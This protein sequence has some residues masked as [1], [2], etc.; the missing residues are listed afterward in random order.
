MTTVGTP[1]PATPP[2]RQFARTLRWVLGLTWTTSP[3][4]VLTVLG[5]ALAR[6]TVAAGLALS[7]RGLINAVVAESHRSPGHLAPV[8]PWLLAALGFGFIEVLAPLGSTRVIQRL[9]DAIQLRVNVDIL[10]HASLLGT[11][12]TQGPSGRHLLES[13]RD[14]AANKLG[15][16]VNELLTIVSDGAQTVLLAAV[17]VH[18]EPAT[19]VVVVPG[20]AAYLYA[21]WRMT[22]LTHEAAPIRLLRQRWG[23]YL[24]DLLTGAR[25]AGHVRLLGLAPTLIDR[26]LGLMRELEESEQ[27]RRRH[28]F[29]T[30]AAFGLATTLLLTGVLAFVASRVIAGR[31]T[32]G[33]VAVFAAASPR[34]RQTVHRLVTAVTRSIEALLATDAILGFLAIPA[35]PV[36]SAASWSASASPGVEIEDVWFTYPGA[37]APAL[38]GVSLSVPPGEVVALAGDNGAG[39]TTL[40]KLL[41]GLYTPQKGRILLDGRDLREWPFEA[42]RE[43]LVLVSPDSPRF[44]ATARDNIAFGHWP[45]L[46]DAPETVERLATEAGV[47]QRLRD[48]PRGYETT[49]GPAFG[50]R[51][52]SSGEWQQVVL[53]RALTRPASLWLLDEPTAHV[54]QRAERNQLDRLRT[55]AAG[56]TILL[57]SHRPGVLALASRIV[58]LERGRVVEAGE[59][60]ELLVRGGRYAR[61]VGAQGP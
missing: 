42:L 6:S 24:A 19:L 30:G 31:L 26:F 23:R 34:L 41:A 35:P 1:G 54:D 15:Q 38:A 33:D 25:S 55:L 7:A 48:L 37:K 10:R 32:V 47:H 58:V 39:K 21:E 28:Q 56:R 5:L 44:E 49:L 16:L 57:A 17:L 3:A 22:R 36:R 27:T 13:A 14:A 51:D 53:A 11:A 61:L 4:L 29:A 8:L 43:R 9:T 20:A 60:D 52:L 46:A 45:T 50:E 59:R 40:M 18:I 2:A 12:D